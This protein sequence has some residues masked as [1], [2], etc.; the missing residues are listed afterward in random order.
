MAGYDISVDDL[1]ATCPM[2]EHPPNINVQLKHHQLTLLH[3][4]LEY[5]SETIKLSGFSSL[6]NLNLTDQDCFRTH[7]GI[8]AD[9]VGSGKSYVVLALVAM[10]KAHHNEPI[11]R[12]YG[13]SKMVVWQRDMTQ[14]IKTNLLVIPHN[15]V[16]Q[17]EEYIRRFS[18]TMK[19]YRVT[20]NR[21]IDVLTES[22]TIDLST[23]D[24]VLVTSTFYNRLAHTLNARSIKLQ[25]VIFDEVDNMNIPGCVH[26]ESD[27]YW[28]VTASYGNLLYPRGYSRW[29]PSTRRYVQ[30]A[31]G[32]K[33]AGF[34]KNLFTDLY[35]SVS[36][37][38]TKIL[39]VRNRDAFV[40]GSISLPSITNMMVRCR[41]P[42]TISVLDGLV[43]KHIIECLNAGDVTSAIQYINPQNR[44]SEENIVMMLIDR[45]MRQVKN[46]EVRIEYTR[47]YEFETEAD[48]EAEMQ[49]L[50]QRRDEMEAKVNSIKAR[51]KGSDM[52][53]VCYDT[54][55]N[56]TVVPC[57][58]NAYCFSCLS[59]WLSKSSTCPLCKS[60]LH[61][62]NVL[63]VDAAQNDGASTSAAAAAEPE[64]DHSAEVHESNDKVKN[65]ENILRQMD[66]NSKILLFSSYENSFSNIS[67]VLSTLPLKV[68]ALKGNVGQIK[69]VVDRYKTGDLNV[70]LVNA[71]S[72]GAGLN[73]ENTQHII[74]FH[75]FDSEIEKQIIGRA[76]RYGRSEALKVW[77]LLYEN[78][79]Q[80]T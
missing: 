43:D 34:V 19:Y 31:V 47:H 3:R 57:C 37:D 46:I 64:V 10:G 2:A 51:V 70:L 66:A 75:K 8:L 22:N 52:C 17:W 27:F 60:T 28:F 21:D 1:D 14:Y 63:V 39:V 33:N 55:T 7:V 65:L 49:K 4:C 20:K 18:D 62:G 25:R 50:I 68:A 6:A 71:K 32:L 54:I 36:N 44:K 9:K 26:V 77:Y 30:N 58:S 42:S 67:H 59:I 23:Y 76:H 74:M 29:D 24:I 79:M 45:Y 80:F 16:T 40:D 12:T 48:K 35:A 41:T 78:E 13:C 56:K 53:S 15:L 73:L 5:E 11:I 69:N 61:I 72:Y 38:Y